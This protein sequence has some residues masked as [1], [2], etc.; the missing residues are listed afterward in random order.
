MKDALTQNIILK[1]K[2][3][4]L[5]TGNQELETVE[6]LSQTVEGLKLLI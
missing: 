4:Q 3:N 5:F 1:K 2:I 6:G